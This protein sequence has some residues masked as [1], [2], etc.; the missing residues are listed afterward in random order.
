MQCAWVQH[1]LH[2]EEGPDRTCADHLVI[3][4]RREGHATFV[5]EHYQSDFN[6]ESFRVYPLRHSKRVGV[7]YCFAAQRILSIR[8]H[9]L[10]RSRSYSFSDSRRSAVGEDG[11]SSTWKYLYFG[12][13]MSN[14]RHL[15]CNYNGNAS[16]VNSLGLAAFSLLST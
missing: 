3:D 4:S 1:V 14:K 9:L 8:M 13:Q 2:L 5:Q 10:F 11:S 12:I 6:N 7:L 15:H 16:A